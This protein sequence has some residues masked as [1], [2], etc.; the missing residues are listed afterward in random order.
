MAGHRLR[1]P[2][3]DP[4]IVGAAAL[5][6][7]ATLTRAAPSDGFVK[8]SALKRFFDATLQADL[9]DTTAAINWA[10][11]SALNRSRDVISSMEAGVRRK[12]AELIRFH[13]VQEEAIAHAGNLVEFHELYTKIEESGVRAPTWRRQLSV[14]WNMLAHGTPLETQA[15]QLGITVSAAQKDAQRGRELL[16]RHGASPGLASATRKR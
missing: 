12:E 2:I 7:L 4:S 5:R 11:S 1:N 13:K 9:K 10:H 6:F 16:I 15:T 8:I 14:C 3:N